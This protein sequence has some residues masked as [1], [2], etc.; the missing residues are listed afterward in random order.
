[1]NKYLFWSKRTY[2]LIL[3]LAL[4][5]ASLEAGLA[6]VIEHLV[7][8]IASE[9]FAV[10]HFVLLGA[11][12]LVYASLM[13]GCYFGYNSLVAWYLNLSIKKLSDDLFRSFVE[14]NYAEYHKEGIATYYSALTNDTKNVANNYLG[15]LLTLP[16]YLFTY[17]AALCVSLFINW[18][19]ALFLLAFSFLVF[20]VPHLFNG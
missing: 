13:I 7:D 6:L 14:K 18:K 9:T 1:M 2:V 3:F 8:Y 17:F 5:N 16:G 10:S 4:I 11:G 20:L 19:I 12:A 15:P